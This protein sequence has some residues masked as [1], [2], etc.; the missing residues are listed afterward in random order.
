[1]EFTTTEKGARKLLKDGFLYVFQKN[2]ANDITSWDC[3]NRRKGHCK[4]RVKLTITDEFVTQ[5]N[6]H[7]H[8]PSQ[9]NCE[10]AKV[11]AGIKRRAETSNDPSRQILAAELGGVTE[12]AAV[13]LPSMDT[14]RRNIRAARQ[15]INIPPQPINLAAIPALPQ[16]YTFFFYKHEGKSAPASL[17]LSI[18]TISGSIYA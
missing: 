12:T 7:A 1:M 8:A 5:I 6:E 4:A 9:V 13:N 18:F 3:V 15:E 17:M 10:V 14:M 2:L 16:A 11:K